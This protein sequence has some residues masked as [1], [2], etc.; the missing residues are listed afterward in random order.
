M[1]RAHFFVRLQKFRKFPCRVPSFLA[2]NSR[3]GGGAEPPQFIFVTTDII[4]VGMIIMDTYINSPTKVCNKPIFEVIQEVCLTDPKPI[5][6]ELP[7]E[8]KLKSVSS[9]GTVQTYTYSA[10]IMSNASEF[11]TSSTTTT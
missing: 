10:S 5:Y 3:G 6:C 9:S 11:G 7:G 2:G 8:L 1:G 4:N